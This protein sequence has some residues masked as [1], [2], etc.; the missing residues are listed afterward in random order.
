MRKNIVF[1][2]GLVL[3]TLISKAQS[4]YYYDDNSH[5]LKENASIYHPLPQP[6]AQH[7][8]GGIGQPHP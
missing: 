2:V 3:L 1:I 6:H 7:P 8:D 4:E 5:I